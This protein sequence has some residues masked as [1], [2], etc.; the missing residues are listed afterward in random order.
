MIPNSAMSAAQ[1]QYDNLLPEE[2]CPEFLDTEAGQ[3]WLD[4]ATEELLDGSDHTF[5]TT[6][7]FRRTTHSVTYA[8]LVSEMTD[9]KEGQR[10]EQLAARIATGALIPANSWDMACSEYKA[11]ARSKA[12]ELLSR[13]ASDREQYEAQSAADD[14]AG[15]ELDGPW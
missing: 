5:S 15:F 4:Q 9:T 8:D 12:T 2:D 6:T 10:L 11:K 7:G 1:R 13:I 14:A 3:E